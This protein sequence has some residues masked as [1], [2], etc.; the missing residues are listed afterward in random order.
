MRL[1]G[2]VHGSVAVQQKSSMRRK[3]RARASSLHL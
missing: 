2:A 3:D 1:N